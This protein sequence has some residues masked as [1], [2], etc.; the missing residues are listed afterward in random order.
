MA[1]DHETILSQGRDAGVPHSRGDAGAGIRPSV[2]IVLDIF[3]LDRYP[4]IEKEQH[5]H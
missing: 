2:P 1:E 5:G 4:T 3:P